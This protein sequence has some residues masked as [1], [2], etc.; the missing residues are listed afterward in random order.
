MTLEKLPNIR[1]DLV[2]ND[3][4]WETWNFVQLTE[5]LRLWTGRNPVENNKPEDQNRRDRRNVG[6]QFQAQQKKG[7]QTRVCVYCNAEKHRS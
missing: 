5:A 3:P 7:E 2:R 4:S 1:G 6:Y